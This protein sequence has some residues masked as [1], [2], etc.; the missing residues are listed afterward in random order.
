MG[1]KL[2]CATVFMGLALMLPALSSAGSP[3]AA[4]DQGDNGPGGKGALMKYR[5]MRI[6]ELQEVLGLDEQ[7]S[8]KLNVV[9]KKFDEQ[10]V[11]IRKEMKQV[12]KNLKELVAA[13]KPDDVKI[14]A[15]LDSL[16]SIGEKMKSMQSQEIA[17][18][19]K[20]LTPLQQAKFVLQMDQIRKRMRDLVHKNW[21]ER[22]GFMGP[23][24]IP[25]PPQ[26]PNPPAGS[27][28]NMPPSPPP[29]GPGMPPSPPGGGEEED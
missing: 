2:F 27:S 15:A 20:I 21:N 10:R 8:L 18:V 16:N 25:P 12:T 19:R 22:G 23:G 4:D 1:R 17:E 24:P 6:A 9:L 28:M 7:T 29:G 13:P 11:A 5:L 26:G 3:P 14:T